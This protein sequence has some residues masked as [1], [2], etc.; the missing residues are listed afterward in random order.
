VEPKLTK[1]G[2]VTDVQHDK[3]QILTLCLKY[4]TLWL[5][6]V[7]GYLTSQLSKCSSANY[8]FPQVLQRSHHNGEE[9][10]DGTHRIRKN[11]TQ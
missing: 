4:H 5:H 9:M 1:A 7:V 2:K 8:T 3:Y 11:R 10:K 6:F